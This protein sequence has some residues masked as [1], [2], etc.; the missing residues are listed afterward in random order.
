MLI[1]IKILIFRLYKSKCLDELKESG[2][3]NQLRLVFY[4]EGL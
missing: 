2:N 3:R 1:K 4:Y